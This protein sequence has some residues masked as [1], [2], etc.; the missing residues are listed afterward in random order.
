MTST[1]IHGSNAQCPD[2][3]A[4]KTDRCRGHQRR[5]SMT[6]EQQ[7]TWVIQYLAANLSK[8]EIADAERSI[9]VQAFADFFAAQW[10]QTFNK[11]VFAAA[12][13]QQAARPVMQGIGA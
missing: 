9:T 4:G 12:I 5:T 8:E 11:M 2:V 10:P 6:R 13:R 7:M 3:Q 1:T